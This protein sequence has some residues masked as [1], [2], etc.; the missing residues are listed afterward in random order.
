VPSRLVAQVRHLVVV[1]QDSDVIIFASQ[2]L[3]FE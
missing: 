3:S 2:R 1:V